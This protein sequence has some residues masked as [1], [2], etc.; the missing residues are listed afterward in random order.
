M[1]LLLD[2]NVLMALAWENHE[3]F[4]KANAWLKRVK[5]FATCPITQGG[6]VRLSGNP[7]WGYASGT[8]DAFRALDRIC[9][10]PRHRF[11]PD[12]ISFTGA[13]V[14]RQL[15]R[16]HG[17]VTDKY[18]VALAWQHNGGL[19]SFDE[20]LAAAFKDEPGMVEL[21]K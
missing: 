12:D 19:A 7:A 9:A 4:A 8:K 1:T 14:R 5:S 17:Q 21:I 16:G 20:P 15:I 18:L 11:F 13:E 2:T 6:F 10:D 3:H